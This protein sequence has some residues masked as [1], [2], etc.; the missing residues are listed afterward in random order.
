M[1]N[2]GTIALEQSAVATIME[3]NSIEPVVNLHLDSDVV[4]DATWLF[5]SEGGV[6]VVIC[7]SSLLLIPREGGASWLWRFLGLF[8]YSCT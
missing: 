7:S 8:T 2:I 5:G 1:N 3:L 6:C 4:Q